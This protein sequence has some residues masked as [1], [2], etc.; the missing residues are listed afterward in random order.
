[1]ELPSLGGNW[2][3]LVIILIGLFY[4]WE[5]L[6]RGF[7]VGLLDVLGF[8]L[9]FFASLKFYGFF[10][11]ILV[12]NFSL[13]QGISNA[14]GFLLAGLLAQII[15]SQILYLIF[16][17]GY[18]RFF[19]KL[20]KFEGAKYIF[21]LERILG[22]I[23]SLGQGIIFTA[24]ILTLFVSLPIQGAI[25]KDIVSSKLG[26]PLVSRTQG[27][28]R[29][30]NKIFGQA[31][32]ESLTFITVNPNSSSEE[33][34][35]LRFTQK[36]VKVDTDAERRMFE[37]VNNE[38]EKR[39]LKRLVMSTQL[40]ELSRD[41]ARDMFARGYFSHYN[42][43]GESPFDRMKKYNISFFAAG[44]NLALAPNVTLAHQ[45]L[46][47]SPGHR[48]NILSSDFGTVGIGVMDGGI[49]GEMFVQ[50]FTD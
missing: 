18:K 13:P 39:G 9:S 31:V 36:D 15:F 6:S 8:V 22:F 45:G 11:D 32:N 42:P 12:G 25:K 4:I 28:E 33:K 27:L 24:F 16:R 47:N 3:D 26:G 1:M 20:Q 21:K 35:D 48:A 37:M 38:R 49:Y 19:P 40:R 2:V 50:E 44:E 7:L 17:I 30:I 46:M 14:G 10:G 34:V 23:P 29:E 5:G 41:Y 43:E